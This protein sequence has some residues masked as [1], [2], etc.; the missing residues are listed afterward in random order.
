M[1]NTE[2]VLEYD[3]LGRPLD[4][5]GKRVKPRIRYASFSGSSLRKFNRQ[6]TVRLRATCPQCGN[7]NMKFRKTVWVGNKPIHNRWACKSCGTT[8]KRDELKGVHYA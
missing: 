7:T 8:L 5:N 4:S 3:N 2:T 1:Q 6:N